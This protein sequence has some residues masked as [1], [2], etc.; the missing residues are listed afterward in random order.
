MLLLLLK[1]LWGGQQEIIAK[2]L[3]YTGL[4]RVD[5]QGFSG[6]IWVFWKPELV[7]VELIIKQGQYITMDIKHM[8][9]EPWYFTAI[10]TSPDPNKRIELW[11]ELKEFATTH[12]KLWLLAGYFNL[13]IRA[14]LGSV[15]LVVMKP[16]EWLLGLT[17]G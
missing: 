3:N 10:Y 12:N 14:S 1:L 8:E 9:G 17:N 4:T 7:I 13:V 2:I 11:R 5:A 16:R 6:G 15:D